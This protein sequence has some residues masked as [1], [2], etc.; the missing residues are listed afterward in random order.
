M[1][2]KFIEDTN[3]QYSIRED[4]VLIRHY[5]INARTKEKKY[6]DVET[7]GA[8]DNRKTRTSI[9]FSWRINNKKLHKTQGA[10]LV[11]YFGYKLCK[12]SNCSG[13]V[14]KKERYHCEDCVKKNINEVFKNTRK[15]EIKNIT[16]HY[17][18]SKLNISIHELTNDMYNLYK[19]NLYNKRLLSKKT[20]LHFNNFK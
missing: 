19:A 17:V 5:C 11:E 18:S 2:A 9:V 8:L 20:G 6:K 3:E 15:A 14:Y 4:G 13:K 16:K 7:F 12:I 10:L 1:E